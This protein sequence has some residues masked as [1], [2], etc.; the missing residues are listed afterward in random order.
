MGVVVRDPVPSTLP[1]LCSRMLGVT[2]A[3][4]RE[5]WVGVWEPVKLCVD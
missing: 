1:V 4:F 2:V 5:H 3:V